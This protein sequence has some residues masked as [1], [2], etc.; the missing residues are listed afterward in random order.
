MKLLFDENLSPVLAQRLL[1][2]YGECKHVRDIGLM[3]APDTDV[4][5]FALRNE[6]AIVTKDSDFRH[7][8]SL[9]GHPPKVIWIALGNCSTRTVEDLLR[10][11]V[12]EVAEFLAD[13]VKAF[14][15]LL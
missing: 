11:H 14:L 9:H 15:V 5:E 6:L 8:C 3:T 1:N 2:C 13:E 4:W 7:R 10:E 12:A